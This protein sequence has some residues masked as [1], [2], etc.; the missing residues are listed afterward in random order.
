MDDFKIPEGLPGMNID[1]FRNHPD[2][3][4]WQ[5][6]FSFV[7]GADPQFGMIGNCKLK[8]KVPHW[9]PE[10][11]LTS[12]T[13]RYVNGMEPKPKF[14]LVCGDMLDAYP[15][16]KSEIL[17]YN[18]NDQIIRD[19]QYEDFVKVVQKLDSEIRLVFVCGNHDVADA[20]TVKTL[21]KYRGQFGP[22]YF[23]FW[24]GGVKFVVLNSQYFYSPGAV[25]EETE[26]HMKF[27]EEKIK[28]P[29]AKYIVV[30]QHIP[31]FGVDPEEETIFSNIPKEI[32][33]TLLEKLYEAGVRYVCCGHYHKNAGGRYKDL[34]LIVTGPMGAPFGED[35]SGFRIFHVGQDEITHEYVKLR[36][37]TDCSEF[38]VGGK[39][40]KE[41]EE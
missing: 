3:R 40:T 33:L 23:T 5:G 18:N 10:I 2:E 25:P 29:S 30:F 21:E 17:H 14:F 26:R 41:V 4:V 39:K 24:V 15:L 12:Q 32:R 31:F 20:P 28:D 11:Q 16:D 19:K 9:E 1:R 22:D 36:E 35:P 8:M 13:I 37:T 38:D 6:P 7:L 34:E 27:I